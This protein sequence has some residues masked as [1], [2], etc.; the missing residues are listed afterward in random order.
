LGDWVGTLALIVEAGLVTLSVGMLWALWRRPA[1][2]DLSG[3][4]TAEL[5]Q[6]ESPH[7]ANAFVRMSSS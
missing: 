1:L 7:G 5:L 2:G 3:T 4:R 6:A